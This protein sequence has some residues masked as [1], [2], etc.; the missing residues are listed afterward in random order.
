MI[1]YSRDSLELSGRKRILTD[2]SGDGGVSSLVGTD[3]A[4]YNLSLQQVELGVY[5]ASKS[6]PKSPWFTCGGATIGYGWGSVDTTMKAAPRQPISGGVRG[7]TWSI[8]MGAG[9]SLGKH[10]HLAVIPLTLD[11]MR[12][13]PTDSD[14]FPFLDDRRPTSIVSSVRLV[15]MAAF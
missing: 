1:R 11:V 14:N 4:T 5:G 9:L 12:L 7:F 6:R 10:T 13:K 3:R 2:E 15:A 8:E